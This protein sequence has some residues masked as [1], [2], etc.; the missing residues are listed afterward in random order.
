MPWPTWNQESDASISTVTHDQ[1]LQA[2]QP[3]YTA[4]MLTSILA[5]WLHAFAYMIPSTFEISWSPDA[6]KTFH[7]SVMP[8]SELYIR[9]WQQGDVASAQHP[10]MRTSQQ[11]PPCIWCK[12]G[13]RNVA[14]YRMDGRSHQYQCHLKAT[15]N[16]Y[17]TLLQKIFLSMSFPILPV[18]KIHICDMEYVHRVCAANVI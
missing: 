9:L 3:C 13:S 1:G 10:V 8:T 4:L 18:F 12:D 11:P 5:R 17:D 2:K 6:L 16:V 7:W 14:L 15:F